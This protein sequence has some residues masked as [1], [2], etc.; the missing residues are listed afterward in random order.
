MSNHGSPAVI[1]RLRLVLILL[2]TTALAGAVQAQPAEEVV[3]AFYERWSRGDTVGAVALWSYARRDHA[4]KLLAD[5]G[6]VT[7]DALGIG[8]PE[9]TGGSGARVLVDGI[10]SRLH[11]GTRWRT[12]SDPHRAI[13][14]L[15]QHGQSWWITDWRLREEALVSALAKATTKAERST[16][17]A[18]SL[19]LQT[20][21]LGAQLCRRAVEGNNKG[22]FQLTRDLIG[23]AVE[24]GVQLRDKR[25]QAEALSVTSVLYRWGH[26]QDYPRS[27]TLAREAASAAIDASDP[28]VLARALQR[29]GRTQF[30]MGA[31]TSDAL[32]QALDLAGDLV[33]VTPAALAATDLA[34]MQEKRRNY[35][36]ALAYGTE[37]LSL[38]ER[39]NNASA[40]INASMILG[41]LNSG[42]HDP[43]LAALH[44]ERALAVAQSEGYASS[45]DDAI[46]SLGYC[47]L[48]AGDIATARK[49]SDQ[50]FKFDDPG[51]YVLR[52]WLAV[53]ERRYA[54]AERDFREGYACSLNDNNSRANSMADMAMLKLDM[55]EIPEASRWLDRA[56]SLLADS[57]QDDPGLRYLSM[58]LRA[59]ISLAL[60]A[61]D[62]AVLTLRDAVETGETMAR[63]V[64]NGV[65]QQAGGFIGLDYAYREL[66]DALV[67]RGS[68]LEAFQYSERMRVRL[69]RGFLTGKR[70]ALRN[71]FSPEERTRHS[72]LIERVQSL[73]ENVMALREGSQEWMAVQKQLDR[74]RLEL[75]DFES[76]VGT[77]KE[78]ETIASIS[79]ETFRPPR[80]AHGN[81]VLSYVVSDRHTIIFAI[82]SDPGG[83]PR[84]R[85]TRVRIAE[86][87]LTTRV[88]SLVKA[89]EQ[90]SLRYDREALDLYQ[91]LVEPVAPFLRGRLAVTIVPDGP[92]WNVPFHA[93]KRTDG[94][95]LV[96]RMAVSYA[97]AVGFRDATRFA[98]RAPSDSP[99]EDLVAFAD[100]TL[101]AASRKAFPPLPD[102]DREVREIASLYPKW[103][104][105]VRTG[106]AARESFLRQEGGH[107]RILHFA[108]HA[109][110]DLNAPLFSAVLL[111]PGGG[112]DGL[113]EVREI[114]NLR[115]NADLAALSACETGRGP[116][117]L[118]EGRI[119]LS[120]AFMLAGCASTIVSQWKADSASTASLMIEF[121]R[122][123]VAGASI[124]EALRR[125]Q[126]VLI[127]SEHRWQ[128]YYW[129]AFIAMGRADE[130]L[131]PRHP[132]W[133]T[134]S[135][136]SSKA[137]ANLRARRNP[138]H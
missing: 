66:I 84:I 23:V 47:A 106:E 93:L 58:T 9:K 16:L 99:T 36:L 78:T 73:N 129:A 137:R 54:D 83:R 88:D 20:P 130:I 51:K 46:I 76:R 10:V 45:I 96:E 80:V 29:L 109:M 91:S 37:A 105:K 112:D 52:A 38:A 121:H 136:S 57:T 7:F 126:R 120:W 97:P 94:T 104:T 55:G 22:E 12:Y 87:K 25:V 18:E 92:L 43:R 59:R 67:G 75:E 64:G 74:A 31:E 27:L 132:G 61:V 71:Q 95:Y 135:G 77:A 3:R 32:E 69:L 2:L 60:G 48:K 85:A 108:T 5:V 86:K 124:A 34:R 107:S 26:Q 41:G 98:A 138:V 14:T 53:Q 100:P 81:V 50:A 118:S 15:E 42:Q 65:G 39:A 79:N 117:L 21:E 68:Y 49:W 119:S 102:A 115:L 113:L 114:M 1:L 131:Y 30:V 33:D 72:S 28:D 122:Q 116:V 133:S 63:F 11:A 134:Q 4:T 103:R 89:L 35:R 123:L 101:P 127:G 17:L 44:F 19:D 13:V 40:I 56:D 24:L 82:D 70:L 8:A 128:P 125:A 111:A 110:A 90:R 62:E 6:C